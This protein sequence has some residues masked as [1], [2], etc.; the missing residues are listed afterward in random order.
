MDEALRWLLA[1]V[2]DSE[3]PS[4]YSEGT[5]AK[6]VQRDRRLCCSELNF[7]IREPRFMSSEARFAIVPVEGGLTLSS[8]VSFAK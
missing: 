4:Q 6:E 5:F 8:E 7:A 2:R 3:P 1:L